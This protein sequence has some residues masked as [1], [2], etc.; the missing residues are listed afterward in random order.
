VDGGG[1]SCAGILDPG[2][3]LEPQALVGMKH[4]GGGEALLLEAA[5]I[6]D[7][8]RVDVLEIESGV[9]DRLARRLGDQRFGS[10]SSSLPNLLWA[11]PTM[12]AM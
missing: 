2:R 1:A 3:R 8:D 9:G 10:S 4:K 6:A 5:E 7:I 11:H 12:A